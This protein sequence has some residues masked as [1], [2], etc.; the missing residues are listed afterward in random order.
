MTSLPRHQSDTT[1]TLTGP[2]RRP[3]QMLAAQTY[4][5][6]KSVHDE[7]SAA[8]LG[9]AG[10][11]I[12]GPTHFS[13]FEPLAATMWGD[14]WFR[15]GCLSA[16][17]QT[18]V[19]EGEEVRAQM[20]I[21]GPG[22]TSA[23]IDANKADGTPVLSGTASIGNTEPTE[24][25][26]R[27]ELA[28]AKTL[29]PLY[30]I[31]ELTIGQRSVSERAVAM[32]LDDHLGSLYP[33]TLREKLRAMTEHL[34]YHESSETPWAKAVVP[35]EMLSVLAYSAPMTPGFRVR[36]PSVGLFI[37]LEV[38]VIDGPVFVGQ[39]YRCE[40]QIVALGSSRKT[41]SYWTRS[42]LFDRDRIV[43]E[44]LLHQGVFTAS[45]PGYP[46]PLP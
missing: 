41:E 12:E 27:L 38:K 13:Q 6:H 11:P 14:D 3:V 21:D 15:S 35:F 34:A 23:R 24:L 4:G 33:F 45:Y 26:V 19:V 20:T 43:A 40:H 28:R 22:R 2:W 44:V 17:F 46:S 42:S 29:A 10:A 31:D 30:V 16:H 9:L 1:V 37:D 25:S 5:G 7:A 8:E 36:Q 39:A 32:G 18:M